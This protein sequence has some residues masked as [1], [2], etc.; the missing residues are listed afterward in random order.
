MLPVNFPNTNY[1]IPSGD[2]YEELPVYR[3][4]AQIIS[5]WQLNQQD[6]NKIKKSGKIW[7]T[8]AGK[9]QPPVD[10]SVYDPFILP[11]PIVVH[12]EISDRVYVCMIEEEEIIFLK[13]NPEHKDFRVEAPGMIAGALDWWVLSYRRDDDPFRLYAFYE[14]KEPV[15]LMGMAKNYPEY[16]FMY[17]KFDLDID[18]ILLLKR[19]DETKFEEPQETPIELKEELL[20][21]IDREYEEYSHANALLTLFT[22]EEKYVKAAE[23]KAI[24]DHH[25]NTAETIKRLL[26][27]K[28]VTPIL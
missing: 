23:Q 24:R 25:L 8:V 12:K 26:G 27:I 15:E 28:T 10:I 19:V 14:F 7:L 4:S 18:S 9:A 1:T 20:K 22:E 13:I 5:C 21:W 3:D 6:L 11:R 17:Q 16:S 2:S